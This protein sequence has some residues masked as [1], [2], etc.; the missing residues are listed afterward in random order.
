MVRSRLPVPQLA[1]RYLAMTSVVLLI[2]LVYRS[3]LH[4]NQTT[5]ALTFL[6]VIQ[7]VAFSWGL[8]Y[9]VYLSI[10]CTALYNFFFLPPIGTFT[11]AS[12]ENWLALLIFLASG[13]FT[14]TIS[15][16]WSRQ[17]AVSEVETA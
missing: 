7:L 8:V 17:A 5:V 1:L 4:V 11:I 6:V 16:S 12:P 15:E 3:I 2:V 9:S 13:I 10:V 14:S